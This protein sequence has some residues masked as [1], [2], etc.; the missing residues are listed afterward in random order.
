MSTTTIILIQIQIL[1]NVSICKKF[2]VMGGHLYFDSPEIHSIVVAMS[3]HNLS[4][5]RHQTTLVD[6][7]IF[8][9][10]CNI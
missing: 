6:S 10:G 3:D 1:L 9:L 4:R 8:F 7:K 2:S 5:V